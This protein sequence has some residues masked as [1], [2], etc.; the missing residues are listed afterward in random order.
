MVRGTGG[1]TA[2]VTGVLV[3]CALFLS[4]GAAAGLGGEPVVDNRAEGIELTEWAGE[5][6][7]TVTPSEPGE[8]DGSPVDANSTRENSDRGTDRNESK[9]ELIEVSLDGVSTLDEPGTYQTDIGDYEY[10]RVILEGAGGGAS[11]TESTSSLEKDG[12][13]GGFVEA[14]LDVALF[15]TLE[16]D[17][18]E[19]GESGDH[20][21]CSFPTSDGGSGF[22]DAVLD[23]GGDGGCIGEVSSGGGGGG[24]GVT[25]GDGTILAVAG[26]GGGAGGVEDDLGEDDGASGGGGGPDGPAGST[27]GGCSIEDTVKGSDGANSSLTNTYGGGGGVGNPAT[28][29]NEATDGFDGGYYTNSEYLDTILTGTVGGG[30]SGATEYTE[31]GN[32]GAV[33]VITPDI[34]LVSVSGPDT[35]EPGETLTVDYTL[36]N[37][38]G[39]KGEEDYVDL[40]INGSLEGSD[41]SVTVPAGGTTSGSLTVTDTSAY[42]AVE[43]CIELFDYGDQSCGVTSFPDI[44]IQSVDAPSEIA[45]GEDLTVDYTLQ[46]DGGPGEESFV[47]LNVDGSL[48]EFDSDVSVPAGDTTSGSLTFSNTG[49]YN[50][51][52]LIDWSVE[53]FD[54][55]DSAD[56][57]TDVVADP[58]ISVQSVTAPGKIA[59]DQDL[60]VDYTLA[61]S[62][63]DG[64]ES[65]VDLVVGGTS[66]DADTNVFVPGGGTSSGTLTYG[67][68][69]SDFGYGET[70]QWT[71]ELADS[72]D[73][74]SGSTD[75]E[76]A[77]PEFQVTI[78]STNS[79][80]VEDET[81]S[82]DAR[83]ENVG[84]AEDTQTVTLDVGTLG[85]DS[86]PVTLPG[87]ASTTETLQVG[88][89]RDSA[90]QYTAAVSSGNDTAS[91]N[92]EVLADALFDVT[93]TSTNEPIEGQPLTVDAEIANTGD[94][95][96]TQTVGLDVPGLGTTS[97]ELTLGGGVSTSETFSIDTSGGDA[98]D[99]TAAVTSDDD[100]DTASVT[101]RTPAEFDV[102]ITG[103]NEPVVEGDTLVVDTQIANTGGAEDTQTVELAVGGLGTDSMSVTLGAG[104]STT[105][106]F[107]VT[108]K[109]G[110]VGDYTAEVSSDDNTDTASVSVVE[111]ATF[112]VTITS[113]NEPLE[114]GTVEVTAE[115]TNTG[116]V[117]DAQVI[118]LTL[119]GL[120]TDSTAVELGGGNSTTEVFT[121]S[122]GQGDGGTY[123]A[124]VASNDDTD[125]ANV[126]VLAPAEF[127]VN[128]TATGQP[129][130]GEPLGVDADVENVGDTEDTQTVTLDI[131]GL[132]T[133]STAVTLAGGSSTVVSLSVGTSAGDAG[134]YTATVASEDSS[135]TGAV[136]VLEE[137]VFD[138]LVQSVT[139]P[140]EGDPLSVDTEIA[141]VGGVE[142]TQTVELAVDGLGTNST[143]VTLGGGSSTVETLSIPTD[144]GDAGAYT[145]AVSS[146]DTTDT[147]SV[148]VRQAAEFAVTV[149]NTTQPLE[150]ESLGVYTE[151]TN[152]GDVEATQ[153]VTLDVPG[154]GG[155]STVVTL[156]GDNSTTLAL[157]VET[158]SGDAGTYTAAVASDDDTASTQVTVLAR[159]AFQV[160]IV[161]ADDTVAGESL[162]VDIQVE[163][164]G[165]V[166][167]T[168][169]LELDAGPLGSS[170]TQVTLSGGNSTVETLSVGTSEGDAGTYTVNATTEDDQDSTQ[171]QVLQAAT[172]AVR[173]D[174]TTEPVEG[175]TL[176]VDIKVENTG[177]V[178]ATEPVELDVGALGTDD[179]AVTLG[180]GN[181][182]T[183]TL[184][185]GTQAGEAG[186]YTAT[187]TSNDDTD[188]ESVT[189]LAAPEFGVSILATDITDGVLNV[190]YEVENVGDVQDTQSVTFSVKN[191]VEQQRE[192]TLGGGESVQ[193]TF[194]YDIAAGDA[195]AVTTEVASADDS[196]TQ[197]VSVAPADLALDIVTLDTSVV[198]GEALS[199]T[200]EATNGGD[201]PLAET[202]ALLDTDDTSVDDREVSLAGNESTQVDLVWQTGPGDA[203]TGEITVDGPT[204][205]P[206]TRQVEVLAP[207][208]FAVDIVSAGE[209]VEGEVLAVTVALENVGDLGDTQA[210]TLDA[211]SLGT[212]S[213]QVALAGSESTQE[214]LT[215]E[216]G[217]GDAGSYTATVTTDNDTASQNI[218]VLQEAAFAV[219]ITGADDPVE[220]ESLSVSVQVTNTG[221]T[222]ETQDITLTVPGLGSDTV[223]ATL[224]GNASTEETLTVETTAGD[225]GTYT[226]TV[227]SD[228]TTDST[229]VVVLDPPAFDVTV[230]ETSEP[231]EGETLVVT[232]NVT[233]TGEVDDTQ[234]VTLD[235]PG[236]GSD[237]TDIVLGAGGS[238]E[239]TFGIDTQPG[240]AGGYTATVASDDDTD[241]TN[242]TV[243]A[244]ANIAVDIVA[245]A[246][247]VV[248]ESLA[249][250]VNVTNLG[251]IEATQPV[252]LSAGELGTDTTAVTLSGGE[253]VEETLS[254]ATQAGDA[255]TYTATVSSQDDTDSA[256]VTVLDPASFA[257][258]IT[259]TGE[260]VAGE[261]LTVT[262]N[263]TNTG[264][265]LAT[266]TVTLDV[267]PLGSNSTG[268]ELAGG[269]STATT[270]SVDTATDAAGEYTATVASANNSDETTVTVLQAAEF[271]V[272]IVAMSDTVIEGTS[273]GVTVEV[274]NVGQGVG[275]RTLT[276]QMDGHDSV[277]MS[278]T[279]GAGES[280]QEELVLSMA[281]EQL[282]TFNVTAGT[283]DDTDQRSVEV[284]LPT[285]P[286]QAGPPNDVSGDDYHEDTDGSGEFDIFD[287]QVFF[288][289]IDAPEVQEHGW[290][291]DFTGD[292]SIT[293][294]DVQALF[295]RL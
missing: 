174:N 211:G 67:D 202:V 8:S 227:A 122:T 198:E 26:G 160:S 61:N 225:A 54:F 215:L 55:G 39:V 153:T 239:E 33:T 251:D 281:P 246:E 190:T 147:A 192:H 261:E 105:E 120:G 166:A 98:G 10:V 63:G 175:D 193:E 19:G 218:T 28:G 112:D 118:D 271:A 185:V 43:W 13:A 49:S 74:A 2:A 213:T 36:E 234:T 292:G 53:L 278:M 140:V 104:A 106:T 242:L 44:S 228:D 187:V 248:G 209:P 108:S 52:E 148:T 232:A 217:S 83:I 35:L 37:S 270:L 130:E 17:V 47:D 76:G 139:D 295:N 260:P 243:L 90:G 56:G 182:T 27:C 257:V 42:D 290:A 265:T 253:S 214:T 231:V 236:L 169:V 207:P 266:Q 7:E 223:E 131:P 24:S 59:I 168:Q 87:G 113:T 176:S 23:S 233:N 127:A 136:T 11:R 125:T 6:D 128:V 50:D 32:D 154:V 132:G 71:V 85:T 80:V 201:E 149:L 212:N 141:N 167:E 274:T 135:D 68:V 279:L 86:A 20:T 123:T 293:I 252:E 245:V 30:A 145:A 1:P 235:V 178:G 172:F 159:A 5:F 73:T 289:H 82:V 188:T 273:M 126:T 241:S 60:V 161:G 92:V 156:G 195:P 286:N 99:Y 196:A 203:G 269:A 157:S 158:A 93:I 162:G 226:A 283:A 64:T 109:S 107:E 12:G 9:R 272:D 171:A 183:E 275:T 97:T 46:N 288:N 81:L 206:E 14:I 197:S 121:V 291:Y 250:T 51:G 264:T 210:V 34:S 66:E 229:Q 181:V 240:D 70:I 18:A 88:T 117:G 138:V 258:S 150:G 280:V 267:G 57:T 58:D 256:E 179:T 247:P 151:I 69:E 230:V 249:V 84:G 119:D 79:P 116:G 25:A 191:S 277:E 40:N 100:T 134:S 199:V 208:D 189:V 284:R 103:T 263:V 110:D 146:E 22:P 101:V 164:V 222:Q 77:P 262:A 133:N 16:I 194:T 41:S 244:Q 276:V 115:I 216:T 62:G 4:V 95:E 268:V 144:P 38:G 111:G 89:G 31:K 75:I 255:G 221:E 285:L 200:V 205:E 180:P 129:V 3:V 259:G 184:T 72:G 143:A 142:D 220:G 137:A 102:T 204:A 186:T 124:A 48:E 78:Q 165:D 163:N 219:A 287:V 114:G 29:V 155:N 94:I 170:N 91:T 294:F 96:G 21:D 173:I 15:D 177:D 237:Q 238:T 152:T 224:A 65:S 45:P 282:G 254:V